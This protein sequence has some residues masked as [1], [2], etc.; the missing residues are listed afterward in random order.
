VITSGDNGSA[1]HILTSVEFS[2]KSYLLRKLFS[3]YGFDG[4]RTRERPLSTLFHD[5]GDGIEDDDFVSV[6]ELFELA[7]LSLR[8]EPFDMADKK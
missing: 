3:E 4:L 1:I 8:G 7:R 6:L 2:V 5:P